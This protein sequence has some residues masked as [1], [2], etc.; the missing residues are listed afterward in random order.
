M[1]STELSYGY[2]Y[3]GMQG[4]LVVT[5]LT[6]RCEQIAYIYIYIYIFL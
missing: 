2:E 3:M 1:V 4:R 6:D 5:P